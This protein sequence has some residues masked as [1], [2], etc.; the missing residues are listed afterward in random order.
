MYTLKVDWKRNRIASVLTALLQFSSAGSGL[1]RKMF[2]D[3]H[4]PNSMAGYL[5]DRYAKDM[6]EVG[7]TIKLDLT[8]EQLDELEGVLLKSAVQLRKELVEVNGALT[9]IRLYRSSDHLE[10]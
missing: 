2:S 8:E 10:V 9:D 5:D 6:Q 1:M 4:S 7:A 3:P